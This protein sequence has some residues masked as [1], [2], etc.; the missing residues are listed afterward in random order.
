ML[1]NR[2][3]DM[4]GK[5]CSC[6]KDHRFQSRVFVGKGVT[7]Q[8]VTVAAEWKVKK[9]Y[10]L[11]DENTFRA[12]GEY[13][14]RLLKEERIPYVLFC[15][16]GEKTE[17]D[18]KNVGI[19]LMRMPSDCDMILAVGSGVINDIAKILASR[20]RLPF[21]ILATAPSMDGYASMTSS[22]TLDGIKVSLPSRCADVIIGDI[23]LIGNAPK[24][25]LLAGIGDMLAKYISLC[26]WR[27]AACVL[28]EYYCEEI[29][30]LIR[31]ALRVYK[32]R[33]KISNNLKAEE[34]ATLLT[35]LLG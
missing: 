33:N 30:S 12:A 24:K 28:G 13:A 19:A 26:E 14:C 23:N 5:T 16:S 34:H 7:E 2:L 18:E 15:Y 25:M 35:E 6:G 10:V 27:I 29:A 1:L 9:I 4:Q 3:M 22:V 20:T 31:E 32:K 21:A 17:P 8:I 11:A